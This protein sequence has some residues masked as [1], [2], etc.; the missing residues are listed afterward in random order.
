MMAVSQA[1]SVSDI[2]TL[3]LGNARAFLAPSTFANLAAAEAFDAWIP[4]GLTDDSGV[5]VEGTADV[6]ELQSGFPARTVKKYVSSTSINISANLREFSLENIIYQ[7]GQPDVTYA[8]KTSPAATTTAASSTKT[9]I[10]ATDGTGYLPGHYIEAQNGASGA[11]YVGRIKSVSGNDLTL[12]SPLAVAVAAGGTLKA[13]DKASIS[14]G[15]LITPKGFAMKIEKVISDGRLMTI[16]LFNVEPTPQFTFNFTDGGVADPATL[17]FS[18]TS[19]SSAAVEG[20]ALGVMVM[21]FPATP[22][23]QY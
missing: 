7:L 20:G 5:T 23:V 17:P 10:K 12:V 21:S 15:N 22:D 9:L 13:I 16:Y 1:P 14:L 18:A 6:V 11:K 2:N 19:I 8:Y 4:L 3:V